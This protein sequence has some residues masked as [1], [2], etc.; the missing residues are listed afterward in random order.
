MKCIAG[1]NYVLG[2]LIKKQ[3]N[4]INNTIALKGKCFAQP[5][6]WFVVSQK[7]TKQAKHITCKMQ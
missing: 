4:S 3:W 2:N 1:G 6:S 5:Y 7:P